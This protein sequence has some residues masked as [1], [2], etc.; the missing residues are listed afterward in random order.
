MP[1]TPIRKRK[2][3]VP[4]SVS[5]ALDDILRPPST[6]PTSLAASHLLT[7]H[8][9]AAENTNAN[10]EE[11]ADP[12]TPRKS[13]SLPRFESFQSSSPAFT[14]TGLPTSPLNP[15]SPLRLELGTPQSVNQT[16]SPPPST[17]TLLTSILLDTPCS[18]TTAWILSTPS[19]NLTFPCVFEETPTKESTRHPFALVPAKRPSAPYPSPSPPPPP[20]STLRPL[21]SIEGTDA[22][23]PSTKV[24]PPPSSLQ[25]RQKRSAH[26]SKTPLGR[27]PKNVNS[28]R[29]VWTDVTELI[30]KE[31]MMNG[32]SGVDLTPGMDDGN[33]PPK[34]GMPSS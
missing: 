34:S 7:F 16:T 23:A 9:P 5:S 2:A 18:P 19:E 22:A 29:D 28:H 3:S 32:M 15:P 27:T 26:R 12:S 30:W 4:Q 31:R 1:T 21:K 6:R 20:S 33:R 17:P 24:L 25:L 11:G 14:R 10:T 13:G 8:A